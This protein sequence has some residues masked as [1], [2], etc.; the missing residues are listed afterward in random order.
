[1]NF[2]VFC[3]ISIELPHT[4][5]SDSDEHIQYAILDIKKGNIALHYPKS[6]AVGAISVRATE[7]LLYIHTNFKS[8]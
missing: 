1:M 5:D 2:K 7:C 6:A 4:G 3:A 8:R